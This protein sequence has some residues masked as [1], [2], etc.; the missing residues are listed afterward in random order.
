[1]KA[2]IDGPLPSG[3]IW[4]CDRCGTISGILHL[5]RGKWLCDDCMAKVNR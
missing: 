1:M 5:L 3:N 2:A 4:A